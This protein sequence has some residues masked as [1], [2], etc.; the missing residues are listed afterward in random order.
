[1]NLSELRQI[2][3]RSPPDLGSYFRKLPPVY[4]GVPPDLGSY[5]RKLP[6][7]YVGVRQISA[8]SPPDLRQISEPLFVGCCL[9]F[10]FVLFSARSP[11][12]LHQIS[13]ESQPYVPQI[14]VCHTSALFPQNPLQISHVQ[15]P[16][17]KNTKHA[18]TNPSA[19]PQRQCTYRLHAKFTANLKHQTMLS[20]NPPTCSL[21]TS[22]RLYSSL[23]RWKS[24]L[25]HQN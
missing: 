3:A 15:A 16:N 19:D 10:V 12:D 5:F 13:T 20:S 18:Q 4:V 6:P 11:P 1:M 8:R 22:H 23:Q 2:S 7:V 21:Q 9:F 24:R 17:A 14:S 25:A